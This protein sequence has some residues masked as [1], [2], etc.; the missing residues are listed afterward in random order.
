MP[1]K[2]YET[3]A[4]VVLTALATH[5]DGL[6][7]VELSAMHP[8]R[9]AE[10]IRSAACRLTTKGYTQR[11]AKQTWQ[12]TEKGHRLL[13]GEGHLN[14]FRAPSKEEIEENRRPSA[15]WVHP[16]RARAFGLVSRASVASRSGS[17]AAS[18]SVASRSGLLRRG[19]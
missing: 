6:T 13:A 10:T 8:D 16:I 15:P 2:K 4:L 14:N 9:I 3:T 7:L 18:R 19:A 1:D 12:I 17:E 5:P 11:I